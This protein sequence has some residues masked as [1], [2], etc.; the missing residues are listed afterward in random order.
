MQGGKWWVCKGIGDL[1]MKKNREEADL[2]V[3]AYALNYGLR[4]LDASERVKIRLGD[5]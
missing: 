4:R 5:G 2:T 3:S 1:P